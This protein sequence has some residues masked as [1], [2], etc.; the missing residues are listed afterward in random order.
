MKRIIELKHVGPKNFVRKALDE[1]CDR[2]EDRIT[3]IEDDSINLRVVF[4]ENSKHKRYNISLTCHLPK[5]TIVAHEE[6]HDSGEVIK[7][8][9]AEIEKQ[10]DKHKAIVRHEHEVRRSRKQTSTASNNEENLDDELDDA[11]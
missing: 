8:G 9:F 7:K 4:E 11:N 5:K 2:I 1:R 6:G 3:F 10:V